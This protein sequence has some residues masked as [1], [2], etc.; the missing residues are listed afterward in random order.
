M[1]HLRL[2]DIFNRMKTLHN[3]SIVHKLNLMLDLL[4][5]KS[6]EGP[7]SRTK[8]WRLKNS[9]E[10]DFFASSGHS[11]DLARTIFL[12]ERRANTAPCRRWDAALVSTFTSSNT[13][14]APERPLSCNKQFQFQY[15]DGKTRDNHPL[16]DPSEAGIVFS[17][18]C[19]W[20]CVCFVVV[21]GSHHLFYFL[22]HLVSPLAKP[23]RCV[24][25]F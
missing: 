15:Q 6:G 16:K 21:A 18:V 10:S 20:V 7:S 14:P 25:S 19:L 17:S 11:F 12:C 2:Y 24:S 4:V 1:R 13:S 8:P 22:F 9:S 3:S 23:D 5:L